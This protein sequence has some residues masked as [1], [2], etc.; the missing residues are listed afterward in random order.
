M[1]ELVS[2]VPVS[3]E[4]LYVLEKIQRSIGVSGNLKMRRIKI[5]R[6]WK[7]S[8]G[9]PGSNLAGSPA[10]GP[11]ETARSNLT[12][13]LEQQ[14]L[15]DDNDLQRRGPVVDVRRKRDLQAIGQ[16]RIEIVSLAVVCN[17]QDQL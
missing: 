3:D 9:E 7:P 8:R 5:L 1:T 14:I 16:L 10:A 4:I 6:K 11:S 13:V 15:V 2:G 17:G 12:P